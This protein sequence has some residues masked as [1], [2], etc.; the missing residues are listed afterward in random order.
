MI[1]LYT[2]A[3]CRIVIGLVFGVNSARL[4]THFNGEN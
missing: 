2:L 1:A 4:L 3:F